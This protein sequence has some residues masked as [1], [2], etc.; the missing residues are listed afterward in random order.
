MVVCVPDPRTQEADRSL[1]VWEVYLVYRVRSRTARATYWC[2]VSSKTK[3]QASKGTE[4]CLW[5][6]AGIRT[7][8]MQWPRLQNLFGSIVLPSC[9]K[10]TQ[11]LLQPDS[12]HE[13]DNSGFT[14]STLLCDAPSHFVPQTGSCHI[15]QA[16]LELGILTSH[17]ADYC[18]LNQ[19]S[20]TRLTIVI[21]K[22]FQCRKAD[23]PKVL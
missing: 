14:F 23:A 13:S 11:L 1:W 6:K 18:S 3:Q 5:W 7:G 21:L 15:I 20:Q 12:F 4:N 10:N 17:P 22:C 19:V 2:P 9:G 16:C 8:C